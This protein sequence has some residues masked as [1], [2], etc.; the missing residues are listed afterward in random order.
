MRENLDFFVDPVTNEPHIYN[1]GVDEFEVEEVL[2]HPLIKT[3]GRRG[4]RIA[5]GQT[6][7]GRYI[8]VIYSRESESRDI[9]VI[10]AYA[11]RGKELRALRRSRRRKQSG[12]QR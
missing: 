5:L 2:D 12:R 4:T 6:S 10:T 11:L 8:K 7:G 1:H 9:L 3:F